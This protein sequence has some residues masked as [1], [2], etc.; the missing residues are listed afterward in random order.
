MPSLC[1]FKGKGCKIMEIKSQIVWG[2][3]VDTHIWGEPW[4]FYQ[5]NE[6]SEFRGPSRI[7]TDWNLI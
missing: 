3:V 6:K 5:G 2:H 7:Q 1:F 4:H